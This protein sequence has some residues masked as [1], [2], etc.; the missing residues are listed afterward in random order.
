M[1]YIKYPHSNNEKLKYLVDFVRHP[2]IKYALISE[3]SFT[4]IDSVK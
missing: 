1:F 4:S 2:Q 3:T